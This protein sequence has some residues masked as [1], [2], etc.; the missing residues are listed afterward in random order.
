MHALVDLQVWVTL[1]L[2][3][4]NLIESNK[5]GHVS[6][7]FSCLGAHAFITLLYVSSIYYNLISALY[8]VFHLC[9]SNC[10]YFVNSLQVLVCPAPQWDN[11]EVGA[12][13]LHPKSVK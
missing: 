11:D 12:C 1:F 9:I 6:Y 10:I 8:L 5:F 7:E 2:Y 3:W 4:V 13:E